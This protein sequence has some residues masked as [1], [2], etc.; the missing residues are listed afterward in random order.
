M[1]IAAPVRS[2]RTPVGLIGGPGPS[3]SASASRWSRSSWVTAA[4]DMRPC[5]SSP[6]GGGMLRTCAA[7]PE[8]AFPT[9]RLR[10]YV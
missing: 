2:R 10:A 3:R 1:S 4:Q 6:V 7:Q 8:I 9:R 5:Q